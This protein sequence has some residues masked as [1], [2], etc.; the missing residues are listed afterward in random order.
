MAYRSRFDV[1][2]V[3]YPGAPLFGLSVPLSGTTSCIRMPNEGQ[4]LYPLARTL[5]GLTE[6][7]PYGIETNAM[8]SSG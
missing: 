3:D 7:P 5:G 2:D 6:A 1:G 4:L 8:A